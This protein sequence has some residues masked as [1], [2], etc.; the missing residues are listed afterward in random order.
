M[1]RPAVGRRLSVAERRG[2]RI[3]VLAAPPLSL[4]AKLAG[5]RVGVV[6][7]GVDAPIVL[8]GQLRAGRKLCTAPPAVAEA[9]KRIRARGIEAIVP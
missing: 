4:G 8:S 3:S 9:G 5:P 2:L 1:V 7:A 6:L